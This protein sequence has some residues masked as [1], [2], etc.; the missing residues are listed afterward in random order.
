AKYGDS[1]VGSWDNI[2]YTKIDT[3]GTAIWTR[4]LPLWAPYRSDGKIFPISETTYGLIGYNE[5]FGERP[6]LITMDS[7]GIPLTTKFFPFIGTRQEVNQL[8]NHQIIFSLSVDSV[9]LSK[10]YLLD[11]LGNGICDML[12]TAV[13]SVDTDLR[14]EELLN[15]TI[16][17][18]T[19]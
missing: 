16:G 8:S 10:L 18:P 13:I 19:S 2:E 7:S 3:D 4:Y 5:L 6:Y 9:S 11:S 12:D 15:P 14:S 1:H 17:I